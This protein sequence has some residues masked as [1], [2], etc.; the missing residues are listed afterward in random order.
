MTATPTSPQQ[1]NV[2]FFRSFI[3]N[4]TVYLD[5]LSEL[6]DEELHLLDVETLAT[7][8]EVRYDYEKLEDKNSTAAGVLFHRLKVANYFQAAIKVENDQP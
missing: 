2:P 4:K 7:L 8:N 1:R 6:S 3:L 5:K